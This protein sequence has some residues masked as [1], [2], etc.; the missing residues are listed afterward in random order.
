MEGQINNRQILLEG[1]YNVR[2]IG[3]Y[4]TGDGHKT[5]PGVFI[6]ADNMASLTQN[7]TTILQ[8]MGVTLAVDMRSP[9][10]IRAQPSKLEN[11]EG[12]LYENVVMFDGIQSAAFQGAFPTSMGALYQSLLNSCREQYLRIFTLFAQNSG[13][14][15]FH[16]TAGKDRTGVVALLLLDLAGVLDEAIVADYVATE[17]CL[18]PAFSRQIR[19][20]SAIEV[21][22]PDYV[23][24]AKGPEME[25]TLSYLREKHGGAYAYLAG[26]GVD[27]QQL[28]GLR[29]RF[30]Q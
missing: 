6:R 21:E 20:A 10:E 13:I 12:I 14:S 30:I 2:D 15:L 16:C 7:D 25:K 19:Q 3:G 11:F 4:P 29:E 18:T 27:K 23:L 1:A 26:C 9:L 22:V 28:D 5:R 24:R 8:G 17:D